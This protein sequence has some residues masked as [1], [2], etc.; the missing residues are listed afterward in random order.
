MSYVFF[1]G[2]LDWTQCKDPNTGLPYYYN[3]VTKEVTWEMPVEYERF[4]KYALVKYPNQL[5]QWTVCHSDDNA[6][7]YFNEFT[8]EISWEKPE[9]FIEPEPSV[10]LATETATTDNNVSGS[11]DAVPESAYILSAE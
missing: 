8:R 5:V 2:I 1:R 11:L 4:L 9:E 3:I 6:K 7:Y 10:A